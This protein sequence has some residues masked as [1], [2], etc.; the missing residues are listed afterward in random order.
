MRKF[1][2]HFVK[3]PT[4]LFSPL[5]ILLT[6]KSTDAIFLFFPINLLFYRVVP[7]LPSLSSLSLPPPPAACNFFSSMKPTSP[8]PQIL[9]LFITLCGD[10]E[11][12]RFA[13]HHWFVIKSFT[14]LIRDSDSLNWHYD[15]ELD[16]Q[17]TEIHMQTLFHPPPL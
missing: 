12:R 15:M 8:F 5:D 17:T 4:S 14:M 13:R 9:S 6:L 2:F 1:I 10:L 11:W 16:D 7:S 3:F